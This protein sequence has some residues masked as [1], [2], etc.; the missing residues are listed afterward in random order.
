MLVEIQAKFSCD[1]CGTEFLVTMDPAYNPPE[2]WSVFDVAEDAVRGGLGYEDAHEPRSA[3]V[4][5]V[6]D[7]RH[8]CGRCAEKLCRTEKENE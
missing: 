5:M 6:E 1:D 3:Y 7:N 8:L 2:G 4:G